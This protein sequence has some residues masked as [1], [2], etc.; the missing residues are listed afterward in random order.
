MYDRT[1]DGKE[2]NFGVI[3]VDKGS[4]IM[5]DSESRSWWSQLFGEAIKGNMK[6]KKLVKVPSTMTTWKQWRELHPDTTVY[7]KPST[8]YRAQFTGNRFA[9]IAGREP[10]PVKEDDVVLGVEGHVEARAYALWQ[11]A[12]QRVR[13]D[14][15]ERQPVV[16]YLS[17]DMA[18][19]RVYHR[20][21][22][23]RTLTFAM[24]PDDRLRDAETKSTWD[25]VRGVATAG[26]LSGKQLQAVTSTHALWS[27]WKRYRPD[28]VLVGG[29]D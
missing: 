16:V 29:A 10:G 20:R 17:Q 18:T 22:D 21:L 6:G 12:K 14:V 11:L 15:L 2:L 8:P 9:G 27:V 3:G 25:P 26:P 1:F 5:Y 13:N 23:S 19:A 7:V 4:L 28:T 24:A